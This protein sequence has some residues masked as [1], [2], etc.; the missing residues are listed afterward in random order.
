MDKAGQVGETR[1]LIGWVHGGG[2]TYARAN[3]A[4]AC[5]SVYDTHASH[6]GPGLEGDPNATR[7]EWK[8][9]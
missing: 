3:A 1:Y 8:G 4:N 7:D 6:V 5:R 2:G 9:E